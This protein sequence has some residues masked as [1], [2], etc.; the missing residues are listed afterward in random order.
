M[1]CKRGRA[2]LIIAVA[3]AMSSA[4]SASAGL[5][6]VDGK[7]KGE[8]LQRP[9][10]FQADV[11]TDKKGRPV[12]LNFIEFR[13]RIV[14]SDPQHILKLEQDM[15]VAKVSKHGG[16]Y[17]FASEEGGSS[18]SGEVSKNGAKVSGDAQFLVDLDPDGYEGVRCDANVGFDAESIY[19][20]G[21]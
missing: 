6:L 4:G 17:L 11:K 8:T 3:L 19:A 7:V 14:C 1:L 20:S 12:K 21:S 16:K 9:G 5:V 18:M 15:P 13:I 10:V 2:A